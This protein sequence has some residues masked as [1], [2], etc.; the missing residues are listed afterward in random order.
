M[1]TGGELL[2]L[3]LEIELHSDPDLATSIIGVDDQVLPALWI[4]LCDLNLAHLHERRCVDVVAQEDV[5]LSLLV[6]T[7][8]TRALVDVDDGW[9]G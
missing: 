9:V 7:S 3:I 1:D 8:L 5:S 4:D 2:N 6:G